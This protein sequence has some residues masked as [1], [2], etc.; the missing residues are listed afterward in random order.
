MAWPWSLKTSPLPRLVL[1]SSLTSSPTECPKATPP[2][3]PP[4]HPTMQYSDTTW[5]FAMSQSSTL[6][7]VVV[8]MVTLGAMLGSVSSLPPY[9]TLSS[10]NYKLCRASVM[11][12]AVSNHAL[13]LPAPPY[14]PTSHPPPLPLPP[15]HHHHH[16]RHQH[17]HLHHHAR[18]IAVFRFESALGRR[19][20]M[21]V[22]AICY[23]VGGAAQYY[24]GGRLGS[25][26]DSLLASFIIHHPCHHLRRPH[27]SAT[28]TNSRRPRH[29]HH[30][31][32]PYHLTTSP[33]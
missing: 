11:P 32:H 5:Y 2:D 31:P 10:I 27:R 29:R 8:A 18:Q 16:H 3:L 13:T 20:E 23:T 24:M 25:S 1:T 7:G 26:V 33:T 15:S 4:H 21:L 9:P 14:S 17:R 19:R 6:Q 28:I 30:P 22:A 12:R